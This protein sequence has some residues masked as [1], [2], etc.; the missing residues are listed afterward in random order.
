MLSYHP[1]ETKDREEKLNVKLK[2]AKKAYEL[3]SDHRERKIYD[4]HLELIENNLQHCVLFRFFYNPLKFLVQR[5]FKESKYV[6]RECL[7]NNSVWNLKLTKTHFHSYSPCH[8]Q[9]NR[10]VIM[11]KN[12]IFAILI[13]SIATKTFLI[14]TEGKTWYNNIV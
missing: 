3:V 8:C 1:G 6:N 13:S 10:K 4:T 5:T 7:V 14:E 12:I 9:M 2:L 11:L